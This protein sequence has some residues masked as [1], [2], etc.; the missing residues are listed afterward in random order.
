MDNH[1]INISAENCFKRFGQSF[2]R[3]QYFSCIMDNLDTSMLPNEWGIKNKSNL[4]YSMKAPDD[5]Q[6]LVDGCKHFMQRYLVRDCI[7]SFALCLDE[8]FFVLLL[9]GK[10]GLASQTLYDLLSPEECGEF[11]GFQF[12][13]LREKIDALENRFGLKLSEMHRR[14]VISLRDIRNCFAHS[15]GVVR[16][17]D[18]QADGEQGRKF[19]WVTL[20]VFGQGVA[21][22]QQ[23]E[24]EL[25]KPFSEE[26]HIY[27]RINENSRSFKV[28]E[29][30]SFSSAE[31]YEIAWSLQRVAIEL[32][33][34]IQN[35]ALKPLAKTTAKQVELKKI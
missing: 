10:K 13:G 18:G 21:S 9:D 17:K 8:L 5:K 35:M 3:A 19:S 2:N 32:L 25:N 28:G 15:N 6:R 12:G 14:V 16:V 7:E 34:K 1:K 4:S 33:K 29:S 24:I 22:G 26:T 30:L 20:H 11:N 27:L 23:Y 31:T